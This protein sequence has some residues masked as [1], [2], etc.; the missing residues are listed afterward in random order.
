MAVGGRSSKDE[1][2]AKRSDHRPQNYSSGA[3]AVNKYVTYDRAS[4]KDAP[5][6]KNTPGHGARPLRSGARRFEDQRQAV[7]ATPHYQP[8]RRLEPGADA[9]TRRWST[10]VSVTGRSSNATTRSP[11]LSPA[12]WAGV[13]SI[14]STMNTPNPSRNP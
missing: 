1:T 8:Q 5:A 11:V 4:I 2:R 14:T 9:A 6:V 12:V 3:Q 10:R 7:A 13:P